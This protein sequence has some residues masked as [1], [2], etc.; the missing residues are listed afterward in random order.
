MTVISL[1]L[2][3]NILFIKFTPVNEQG[4]VEKMRNYIKQLNAKESYHVHI[5]LKGLNITHL[6]KNRKWL[7]TMLQS[8]ELMNYTDNLVDILIFNAPFIAK[9]IYAILTRYT[10]N[11]K[12]K[13]KFIPLNKEQESFILPNI[14]QKLPLI[15]QKLSS[16]T[17]QVAQ[18]Q[19]Q[20]TAQVAQKQPQSTAP[21]AQKQ[22]Q[23]T[24]PVAQKQP[25]ST[26]QVAQKQP[27]ATAP[28]A[29]KQPQSTPQ[30][31]QKQPQSTAPV[32]KKTNIMK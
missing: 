6:S 3:H 13:I 1:D 30:V 21:V 14:F 4:F 15:S 24:A 27:Q 32:A 29:Q 19:P 25:Q 10:K 7:E 12:E 31:A 9:Q 28:V 8:P 22:P 20:S 16:A 23:S 5:D 18:K 26:P 11:I 2:E 17:A